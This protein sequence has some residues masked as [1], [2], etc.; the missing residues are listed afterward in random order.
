MVMLNFV[1]LFDL[2]LHIERVVNLGSFSN[3][4]LANFFFHSV[5]GSLPSQ[6]R[7]SKTSQ[8]QH[9]FTNKEGGE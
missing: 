9:D 8:Q 1:I 2:N 4:V 5:I 6:Q 7:V 3:Y